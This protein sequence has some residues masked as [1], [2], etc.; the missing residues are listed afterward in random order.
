[1]SLCSAIARGFIAL[2]TLIICLYCPVSSKTSPPPPPQT[3]PVSIPDTHLAQDARLDLPVS[4]DEI[5]TSMED[6]LK[7]VSRKGLT[8][9][10]G[11]N[12]SAQ[13]LQIRLKNRPLRTLM[14]A[15]A[16]LLPG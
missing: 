10:A 2:W 14:L 7:K 3:P 11:R 13:K 8:L 1:M 15:L 12:C 16:E 5:G 4:L 6:L 9:R